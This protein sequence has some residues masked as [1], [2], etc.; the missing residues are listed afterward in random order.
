MKY[1]RTSPPQQRPRTPPVKI[2]VVCPRIIHLLMASLKQ[3]DE[4]E[5]WRMSEKYLDLLEN[6]PR[7]NRR[8]DEE[9]NA[10][11]DLLFDRLLVTGVHSG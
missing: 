11:E 7:S 1:R 6:D 3:Y 4:E 8:T 2:K 10:L 5:F 9:Y